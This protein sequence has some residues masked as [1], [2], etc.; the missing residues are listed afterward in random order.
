MPPRVNQE[1]C[2]GCKAEEETLCEQ[3]CP[4][5]LMALGEN[6]KA[7]CRAPRDCWDCMSCTKVCPVGAIETRMPYQLGYHTAK[8]IPMMGTDNITWTCIDIDGNVERF[9]Y[10]NRVEPE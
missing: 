9:R 10:K 7:Y 4:G 2:D 3:I 8:L 1:K 6:Q 5:D